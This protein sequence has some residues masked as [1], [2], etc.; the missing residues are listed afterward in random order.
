MQSVKIAS[1]KSVRLTKS[2]SFMERNSQIIKSQQKQD[3]GKEEMEED[4][5]FFGSSPS[6]PQPPPLKKFDSPNEDTTEATEEEEIE[7]SV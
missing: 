3:Q 1:V 7:E 6:D 2:R 4:L 5:P